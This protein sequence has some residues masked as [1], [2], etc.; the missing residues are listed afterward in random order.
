MRHRPDDLDCAL[1]HH[2]LAP[3]DVGRLLTAAAA[4]LAAWQEAASWEAWDTWSRGE[5]AA[6]LFDDLEEAL[7]TF[8]PPE[9]E[10]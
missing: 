8:A 9:G 6:A 2:G 1:A 5:D 4:L 3:G 7:E 10:A